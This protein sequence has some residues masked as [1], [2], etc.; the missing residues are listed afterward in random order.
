VHGLRLHVQR[1]HCFDEFACPNCDYVDEGDPITQVQV[2]SDLT[3]LEVARAAELIQGAQ[4][5]DADLA[6]VVRAGRLTAVA[7]GGLVG[8]RLQ[9]LLGRLYAEAT[10]PVGTGDPVRVSAPFVSWIS[11]TLLAAEIA[12]ASIGVPLVERRLDLDMSGIPSGAVG[13]R[14]RDTSGR[15]TCASPWRRRAASHLYG[16]AQAIAV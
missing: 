13:R 10:V 11:G 8:R 4:L 12:K 14:R 1:E 6:V 9:D 3:G 5:T 16:P 15:C 7:A 2:V